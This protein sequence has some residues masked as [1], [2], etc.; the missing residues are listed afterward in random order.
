MLKAYKDTHC[1]SIASCV[2]SSAYHFLLY[3]IL[4]PPN[5]FISLLSCPIP[6]VKI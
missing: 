2:C 6:L 1:I 3:R 5:Q 4:W